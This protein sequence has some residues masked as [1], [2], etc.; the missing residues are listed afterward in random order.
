MT[1]TTTIDLNKSRIT[2]LLEQY[3]TDLAA[4]RQ[5]PIRYL[6][7][8][9]FLMQDIFYEIAAPVEIETLRTSLINY[10]QARER[11]PSYGDH[12]LRIYVRGLPKRAYTFTTS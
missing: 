10:I 1:D 2:I 12:V 3:A 11:K 8:D 5:H 6:H 7:F 4:G 9:R